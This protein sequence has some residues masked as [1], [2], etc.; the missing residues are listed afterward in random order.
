MDFS[1]ELPALTA[2]SQGSEIKQDRQTTGEAVRAGG[3]GW[4]EGVLTTTR[5]GTEGSG[6]RGGR[7]GGCGRDGGRGVFPDGE[8]DEADEAREAAEAPKQGC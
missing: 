1:L 7:C 8:A 4:Q 2:G 5:H 6:E 3:G